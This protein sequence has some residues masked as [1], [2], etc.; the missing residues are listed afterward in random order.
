MFLFSMKHILGSFLF[1]YLDLT[2]LSLTC[3][4]FHLLQLLF[5]T[6]FS[7]HLFFR[8]LLCVICFVH[9]LILQLFSLLR[10]L[11]FYMGGICKKKPS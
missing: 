3:K 10:L 9:N 4:L 7:P 5:P 6:E 2:V 1:F 11:V 8:N